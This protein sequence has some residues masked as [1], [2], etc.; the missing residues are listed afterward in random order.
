M[1]NTYTSLHYHFIFNRIL[2]QK[3]EIEYDHRYLW[4]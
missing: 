3:H 1:T 4:G 2:L